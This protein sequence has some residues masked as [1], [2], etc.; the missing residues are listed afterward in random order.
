M[1]RF[2]TILLCAL[3]V[4]GHQSANPARKPVAI[5]VELTGQQDVQRLLDGLEKTDARVT[6]FFEDGAI[7]PEQARTIAE[8]GHE[9]ALT[10]HSR[11]NGLLLSRRNLA[12]Q[13]VDARAVLPRSVKPHWLRLKEGLT[14]GSRQVARV[15]NLAI[16]AENEGVLD[17]GQA[18]VDEVL[19]TVNRLRGQGYSMVTV[20]E[21]ARMNRVKV[22]PGK[23]YDGHLRQNADSRPF[24][25]LTDCAQ[26]AMDSPTA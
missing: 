13:I 23:V 5:T 21:L 20:S 4:S 11:E 6:F 24:T 18:S 14:D 17:L 1:A 15:K 22:R 16:L 12:A 7:E 8:G 19:L 25:V 10:V 9:M 26:T 2:C 3:L